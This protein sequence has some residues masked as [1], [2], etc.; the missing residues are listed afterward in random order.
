[1]GLDSYFR[2]N[3]GKEMIVELGR[4]INLAGGLFSGNGCD[5]S[6]RGKVYASLVEEVTGHS[7]YQEEISNK[8]VKEMAAKL[9]AFASDETNEAKITYSNPYGYDITWQEVK[10]LALMFRGF[11]DAGA[12]LVG[13]W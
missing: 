2:D 3:N 1:M 9:G 4:P 13:W 6:F 10:D 5:G 12:K 8:T 11:G 7:L